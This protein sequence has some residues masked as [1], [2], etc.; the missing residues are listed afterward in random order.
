[1]GIARSY[2]AHDWRPSPQAAHELLHDYYSGVVLAFDGYEYLTGGR[3]VGPILEG[4]AVHA[5]LE[6]AAGC[7]PA[8]EHGA[9]ALYD[10]TGVD[11]SRGAQD[12]HVDNGL[13]CL[14]DRRRVRIDGEVEFRRRRG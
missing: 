12:W 1:M 6:L 7:A 14:P 3:G 10:L 4:F 5:V 9:N 8:R 11:A 2:G 13:G